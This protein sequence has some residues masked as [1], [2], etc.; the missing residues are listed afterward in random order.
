M[1]VSSP[2]KAIRKA[3]RHGF[4]LVEVVITAAIMAM[5]L[6][7]MASAVLLAS[8]AQPDAQSVPSAAI[9]SG[10]AAD[11][12]AAD[13][14]HAVSITTATATEIVFTVADRT[15]DG[16]PETIRYA[17]SGTA[18]AP[19]V[20]QVNGGTA[21]TAVS[22]VREF[23]LVYDKRKVALAQT[24]SSGS[25]TLLASNDGSVNVY[26]ASVSSS[27][28]RGQFFQPTLPANAKT[29]RV[30]RVRV[31]LKYHD[32]PW[33]QTKVQLR[34]ANGT[35]PGDYVIEESS[36]MEY[37]LGLYQQWEE[38]TFSS[39]TGLLPSN[40]LCLVLTGNSS[41]GT[42][43]VQVQGVSGQAASRYYVSSANGGTSWTAS[44]GLNLNYYVYGTVSTP[45][46]VGYQYLLTDV[47]CTLRSGSD[48]RARIQTS[49]RVVNEPQVTG[50]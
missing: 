30:T 5:L 50:P 1:S 44:P 39:V 4:T 16:A 21:A 38:F 20:R 10:R 28:F 46:A 14:F 48:S 12:L 31:K 13:L 32:W 9:A 49:V 26:D 41:Y 23:Q 43:E 2:S 3:S 45:D 27:Y 7:G 15:G 19:L 40:T 36:I 34:L 33:G 25:E 24:Y 42:S 47:R 35:V 29:W 17:W 22:D 37:N 11:L 6:G 8:K 18:G